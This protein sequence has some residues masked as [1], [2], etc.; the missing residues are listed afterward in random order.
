MGPCELPVQLLCQTTALQQHLSMH[1]YS[2]HL[3]IPVNPNKSTTTHLTSCIV[4]HYNSCPA[5]SFLEPAGT[6]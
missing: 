4:Q 3:H 6:L 5:S 2:M 1:S